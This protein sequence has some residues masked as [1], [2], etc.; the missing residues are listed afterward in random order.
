[1]HFGSSPKMGVWDGAIF[2]PN[3]LGFTF[4]GFYVCV[5]FG[6]NPSINASAIN[7]L[8]SILIARLAEGMRLSW[9]GWLVTYRDG[10]PVRRLSP[11]PVPSY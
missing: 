4:G 10:M 7:A 8:W 2:T 6:E 1:M 9:P 11:I 5:N 3:E